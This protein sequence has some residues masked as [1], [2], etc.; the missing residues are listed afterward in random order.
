MSYI[1]YIKNNKSGFTLIE[2]MV[3]VSIFIIIMTI[4]MGSIIN[5]FNAN[6]KAKSL[7]TVLGNLN[8][9][10]ESMSREMRFGKNYHCGSGTV[11]L[12]QNCAGGGTLMSF[13]SS[14]DE[15]VTYRLNG[16]AIEKD[17]DSAGYV[18]VTAP[19]M[20]IDDL[21]FY[22]L[23]AGLGNT[24]QPKVFIKIRSHA[25]SGN[26][27]TNFTLQTLASQRGLDI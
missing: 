20:M 1:N 12:P 15:Q 27:Q 25:G 19:E 3:A 13:L 8:L 17:I 14:D 9:A 4:S 23:G 26:S 16:T 24:L 2:L 21:T 22:T 10:V 11:T 5:I 7:K 6:R 18:R